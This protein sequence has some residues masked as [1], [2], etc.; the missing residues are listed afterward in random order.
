MS[1]IEPLPKDFQ[2]FASTFPW[3]E[4]EI[5]NKDYYF[6]LQGYLWLTNKTEAVLAYCLIDTPLEIVEVNEAF[7]RMQRLAGIK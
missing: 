6:Q 4:T 1:G 2:S 5:P 3:F 7:A